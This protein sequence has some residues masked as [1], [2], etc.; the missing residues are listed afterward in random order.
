MSLSMYTRAGSVAAGGRKAF[1]REC[2][3]AS[4]ALIRQISRNLSH[5][6]YG[7]DFLGILLALGL[8]KIAICP[9][10]CY[11]GRDWVITYLKEMVIIFALQNTQ[12]LLIMKTWLLLLFLFA[13]LPGF[14]QSISF[15]P[16]TTR[17]VII[18]ISDYQ[19]PGIPDLL[20]AHKDAQAFAAYLQSPAGGSLPDEN[21]RLLINQQATM[22]AI[23]G[24]L[25]W[26]V[27]ASGE[28]DIAII[29]FAGHGDVEAKTARQPGFLLAYDC[30]NPCVKSLPLAI[31]YRDIF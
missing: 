25:D 28:N 2:I 18:G 7:A 23:A 14:S 10:I 1:S 6:I 3:Y 22:A 19:D 11:F 9:K 13:T 8:A 29:Y 26:L 30:W 17:A 15:D 4:R 16:G 5:L 24:E 31:T 20:Y 27:E 12:Q 21:I